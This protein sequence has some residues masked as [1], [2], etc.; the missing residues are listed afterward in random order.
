M[1]R[2][3]GEAS[4]AAPSAQTI[5]EIRRFIEADSLGYLSLENLRTGVNGGGNCFCTSCFTGVYPTPPVQLE[6]QASQQNGRRQ[7]SSSGHSASQPAQFT[8]TRD[9]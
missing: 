5:E 8:V 3:P 2:D 1:P 6:V 7:E 4:S 9:S